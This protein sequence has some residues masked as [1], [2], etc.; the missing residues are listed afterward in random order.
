[1]AKEISDWVFCEKLILNHNISGIK[2]A[3][4]ST[5]VLAHYIKEHYSDVLAKDELDR[6]NRILS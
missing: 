5:Y 3:G 4:R 6:L 1:M 2:P